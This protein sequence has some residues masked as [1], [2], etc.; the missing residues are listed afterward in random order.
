ML[1]CRAG[2]LAFAGVP[3]STFVW[4]SR[5]STGRT[6]ELPLGD[7]SL[8]V[9]LQGNMI[10]CR[11][12]LGML[13]AV[14]RR[15]MWAA[16]QPGSSLLLR[17]PFVKFLLQINKFGFGF[18]GGSVGRLRLLCIYSCILQYS[19]L[20]TVLTYY[21]LKLVYS[22]CNFIRVGWAATGQRL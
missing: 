13:V 20:I 6:Q 5:S 8:G 2:A 7:E 22:D 1:R 21:N 10:A 17:L 14:V 4:V 19:E 15:V 16:E 11:W 9:V 18:P 3:C 12:A